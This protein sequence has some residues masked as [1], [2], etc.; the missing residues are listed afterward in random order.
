MKHELALQVESTDIIEHFHNKFEML[1][2]LCLETTSLEMDGVR[3]LPILFLLLKRKK[4]KGK[5]N[6]SC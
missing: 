4:E 3:S 6:K 1:I 5:E 2:Y